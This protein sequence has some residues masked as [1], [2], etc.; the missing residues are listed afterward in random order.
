[1]DGTR[2]EII[3]KAVYVAPAVLTL[4]ASPAFAANGSGKPDKVKDK[5]DESKKD[6]E[7]KPKK[8]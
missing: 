7:D 1:V 3:K 4:S 8:K 5:E 6:K 2:R